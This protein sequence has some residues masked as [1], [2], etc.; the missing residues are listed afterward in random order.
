VF[1]KHLSRPELYDNVI[2]RAD[3]EGNIVRLKDV[4]Q[5]D[6]EPSSR[7]NPAHGVGSPNP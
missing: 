2:L 5:V 3:A 1:V 6:A 7:A 4:G